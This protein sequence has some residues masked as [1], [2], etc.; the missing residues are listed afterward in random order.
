MAKYR[1][2]NA[3]DA[4][5]EGIFDYGFDRFGH[6]QAE[7]Y[8]D[9]LVDR[10][11]RLGDAPQLW[12]TVDEIKQG[13]RRSVYGKHSIYFCTDGDEIVVV[14]ILGRQNREHNL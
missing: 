4:D 3:A 7:L 1:L 13:F 14:R 8:F 6:E 9:G 12:Q 2:T 11:A 5:L 10:L